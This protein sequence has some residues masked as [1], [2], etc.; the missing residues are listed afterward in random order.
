MSVA[1]ALRQGAS[2]SRT[3]SLFDDTGGESTLEELITGVWEGLAAHGTAVCPICAG[4]MQAEHGPRARPIAGR[5][6]RCGT[7]LS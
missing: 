2:A 7:R 5:C 6:E 1:A 3:Q 4:P